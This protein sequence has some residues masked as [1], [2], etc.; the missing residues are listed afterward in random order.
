MKPEFDITNGRIYIAGKLVITPKL[1]THPTDMRK[2][3]ARG[4]LSWGYD[5]EFPFVA[6]GNMAHHISK[7]TKGDN[8]TIEGM[9]TYNNN[10]HLL[11]IVITSIKRYDT[12]ET[13]QW[14]MKTAYEANKTHENCVVCG[15]PLSLHPSVGIL[16]CKCVENLPKV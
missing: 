12:T 8:I 6:F 13:P 5:E 3:Y 16:Y 11:E 14:T 15:K 2:D 4:T 10:A 7:K 1:H 9:L